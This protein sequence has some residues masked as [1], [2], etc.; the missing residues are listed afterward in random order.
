M[1]FYLPDLLADYTHQAIPQI[2]IQGLC[3][4]SRNCL[5]GDCFF[6]IQGTQSHGLDYLMRM[7]PA[8]VL[9]EPSDNWSEQEIKDLA[10]GLPYPLLMIPHLSTLISDISARFYHYPSQKMTLIGITGT[11]GKTSISSYIAQ[12]MQPDCAMLGT[13][14]VG[15]YG[16]LTATHMTTPDALTLQ[17]LLAQLY[18]QNIQQVALEVSSHA[19]VQHR[20][21]GI[22]FKI[23]VF[24]NLSRD[25][26]DYH[27]D[28]EHYAKAKSLLFKQPDLAW[29]VINQE[30]TMGQ[31]LIAQMPASVNLV[32]YGLAIP[33]QIKTPY[34]IFA[35]KIE[36][37]LDQ[38]R[39]YFQSYWGKGDF[40]TPLMSDFNIANLLATM[41]VLLIQDI[42]LQQTMQKIQQVEAVAGRMQYF[43]QQA[44]KP[45]VVVDYAHTPDALKQVLLSL[46][47]YCK[48]ELYCVFGCGGN[49]DKGKRPLMGEVAFAV[50]DQVYL[51]NDNPRNEDQRDIIKDIL[52]GMPN[53]RHVTIE[54]DRAVAICQA[55]TD[56]KADDVVLIAGKGHENV[57]FIGDLEIPFSDAEHVKQALSGEH[58]D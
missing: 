57:Q 20:V 4:D 15:R 9:A 50:A 45:L 56:A 1:G 26:L 7:N 53:K 34:F 19:L 39:V 14:G 38:Q 22:S 17:K 46:K 52:K 11:N 3:L 25:H 12:A 47:P 29:A 31:Q 24:T 6:A 23:A 2:E 30:D 16:A 48:G 44:Q 33:Q 37:H 5:A 42:P 32:G 49:R 10:K 8:V 36:R 54:P 27:G 18:A 55:I 28:M 13:L 40:T 58:N 43:P 51:T 35:E 41:A 21:K